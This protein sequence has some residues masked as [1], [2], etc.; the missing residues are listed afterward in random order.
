MSDPPA[1][2][3][4]SKAE[5]GAHSGVVSLSPTQWSE[6]SALFES[7]LDQPE[8]AVEAR[9]SASGLAADARQLLR[10]MLAATADRSILDDTIDGLAERLLGMAANGSRFIPDDLIGRTFGCWR[11]TRELARGGMG[12]VFEAQRADGQF[13]MSVALKVIKPG[14]HSEHTADRFVE[15]MRTLARLEHPNI[16]RLVDGGLSADG[17]SFFAMELVDGLPITRFADRHRLTLAARVELLMQVCAAVE[18]AHRNLVVHGDLKPS[19]ILVDRA[20]QV[21]LLDFGIAQTLQPRDGKLVLPRFTLPYAAPEQVS[22]QR[23]TTSCDVFGLA[24]VLYEL[25][26]GSAPRGGVETASAD[27]HRALPAKRVEPAVRRLAESADALEIASLRGTSLRPLRRSLSTDLHWILDKGLAIDPS[28]R[29]SSVAELR[30]ELARWRTGMALDSH[31]PGA[32]YRLRRWLG[33]HR[34]PVA[35]AGVAAVGLLIAAGGILQQTRIAAAEAE[36]AHWSKEFLL[37]IFRQADPIINQHDPITVN[38]LTAGAADRLLDDSSRLAPELQ[39]EAAEVLGEVQSNLGQFDSALA[40]STLQLN[41]ARESGEPRKL[42]GAL[43]AHSESLAALDQLQPAIEALRE[44]LSLMPLDRRGDPLSVAASQQLAMLLSRVSEYDEAEQLVEALLVHRQR[45]ASL[46]EGAKALSLIYATRSAIERELGQSDDALASVNEALGYALEVGEESRTYADALT[47]LA[48]L[49]YSMGD[50]AATAKVDQQ[51][52]DLFN[53][54][55]G[56]DHPLTLK[57]RSE[58]AVSLSQLGE[59]ERALELNALVLAGYRSRLGEDNQY[60]AG[61]LA[62]MGASERALG[63]FDESLTHY[64]QSLEIRRRLDSLP[65]TFVASVLLAHGRVL[66]ELDRFDEAEKSFLQGIDLIEEALGGEHVFLSRAHAYYA[67][68]LIETGRTAAATAILE[69]AYRRLVDEYGAESIRTSIATVTLA[70]LRL[71]QGDRPQARRLAER[72]IAVLDVKG[73]RQRHAIELAK[74]K[75]LRDS[76]PSLE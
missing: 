59:M 76:I 47:S 21:R 49:R 38:E 73:I 7:L 6:V 24:A 53:T 43:L 28:A 13:E 67:P 56:D 75:E 27:E 30:A 55:Y 68:V 9:I 54:L 11:V 15:E 34:I 60:V 33:R 4:P 12:A 19:N 2:D 71:A 69:P 64:E 48:A 65:P 16:A 50:A 26:C 61:A 3:R 29:L 1:T 66:I 14:A 23:L 42:M 32:G 58:L 41:L 10:R 39:L 25:C 8:L 74:A 46:P 5:E 63:R 37:S 22:G 35:I 57:A 72:A 20:G 17:I 36:K 62:N 31:P 18:H 52:V 70:Q 44:A 51:V 45:I 40:L